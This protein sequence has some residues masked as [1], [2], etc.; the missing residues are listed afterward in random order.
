LRGLIKIHKEG[1]PIRPI[2][3]WKNAPAYK[4]AKMLAKKLVSHIPLPYT[5]NI[6][7]TVQL[8]N[9]LTDI[10]YG[11]S[12]ICTFDFTNMYSNIPTKELLKI[13]N[14]MCEEQGMCEKTKQEIIKLSQI[15]L[16]QNYFRFHDTIYI[17][18][19]GL[20]MGA[21]TSSMFSEIYYIYN[22]SRT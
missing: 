13:I 14:T 7:N 17:Q 8:I 12:K 19:E 20:V 2:V 11:S 22:T 3:N 1:A 9:N 21:P 4:L 10:P 5:F 6:T 15:L 16:E 18:N